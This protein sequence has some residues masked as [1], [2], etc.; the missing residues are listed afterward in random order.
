MRLLRRL[1][2]A[3]VTLI[4]GTDAYGSLSFDKEL[5]LYEK[6]G[7]P[8]SVVLQIAT[9]VPARV[10][11]DDRAYGSVAVGKVADLFIVNG[12]PAEHVSDIRNVERVVRAGRLYDAHDL[13]VA[14]GLAAYLNQ[15]N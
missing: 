13:R 12:K 7:I 15:P 1:Y 5:E 3:G 2:D 14:S 9:I 6:V 4:P 10:M 8:A 11:K